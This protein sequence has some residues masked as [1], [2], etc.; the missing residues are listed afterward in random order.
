M[1][2]GVIEDNSERGAGGP[3]VS[4]AAAGTADGNAL[5][6]RNFL[7][8]LV[9]NTISLH[10]LW[11][12]R[13]ALGWYAWELSR[14]ELW[15][16]IVAAT[17]FAPAIVFGPIFGVLADRFDRRAASILINSV[18]VINM[19]VL[20]LLT[21]LGFMDVRVLALLSLM[22]GILDGA[23]A[24]VRMSVVPNL[25]T[26]GQLHNAIA[27]GSVAFNLSRFVGPAI[28]GF[29][30]AVFGVATAFVST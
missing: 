1:R 2:T 20:G 9:G 22:Q 7:L 10:G 17:Q 16:G 24:P 18:S 12:Y 29:V 25:V 27:L 6:N 3:G 11:V 23:H 28:A 26:R 21:S 13:V 4:G 19:L 14:S 5:A 8:Y 30:I 15:V